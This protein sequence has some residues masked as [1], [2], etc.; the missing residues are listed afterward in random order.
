M[1]QSC[2]FIFYLNKCDLGYISNFLLTTRVLYVG[3]NSVLIYEKCKL[4]AFK[5]QNR[6][7]EENIYY[8]PRI[9][10]INWCA[11]FVNAFLREIFSPLFLRNVKSEAAASSDDDGIDFVCVF[12]NAKH[13]N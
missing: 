8:R 9:T 6:V 4:N 1:K 2:F 13:G 3:T 10:D 11:G 5:F 7:T 12:A